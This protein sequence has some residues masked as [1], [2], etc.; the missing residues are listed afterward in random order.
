MPVEADHHI[1]LAVEVHQHAQ[2]SKHCSHHIHIHLSLRRGL[3]CIEIRLIGITR[4]LMVSHA[5]ERQSPLGINTV[6]L[7]IAFHKTVTLR[8]GY[9]RC[10]A[11]CAEETHF[12]LIVP[13]LRLQRH[14]YSQVEQCSTFFPPIHACCVVVMRLAVGI[15]AI[16]EHK[17]RVLHTVSQRGDRREIL[18]PQSRTNAPVR[19]EEVRVLHLRTGRSKT[20]DLATVILVKLEAYRTVSAAYVRLHIVPF[21]V[22]G[23]GVRDDR[24]NTGNTV[25]TV[26]DNTDRIDIGMNQLR[27]DAH[28]AVTRRRY[29]RKCL[30]LLLTVSNKRLRH[31]ELLTHVGRGVRPTLTC[32]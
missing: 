10:Y 12:A 25:L 1:Q 9:G 7:H 30:T 24:V 18:K 20:C 2:V 4:I 5:V 23:I 32:Q 11:Q 19:V 13:P 22:R 15:N 14:R 8:N 26:T 27:R 29:L 3:T 31:T 6:M 16:Q 21:P 17:I 28:E